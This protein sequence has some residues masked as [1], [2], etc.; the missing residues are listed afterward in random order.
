MEMNKVRVFASKKEFGGKVYK[1]RDTTIS[2]VAAGGISRTLRAKGYKVR[3][4]TL[5]LPGGHY[6]EHP[7]R[8]GIYVRK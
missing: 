5:K 6:L 7:N 4:V 2:R 8:Y 3:V 1:L